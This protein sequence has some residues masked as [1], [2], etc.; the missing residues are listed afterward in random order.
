MGSQHPQIDGPWISFQG[1]EH[2][3]C[4]RWRKV[5]VED[6]CVSNWIEGKETAEPQGQ[7]GLVSLLYLLL[8][9]RYVLWP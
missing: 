7:G 4:E 9:L 3:R 8:D 2:A 1:V 6:R 5:E